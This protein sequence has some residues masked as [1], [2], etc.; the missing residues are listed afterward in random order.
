MKLE[1]NT[2]AIFT[3]YFVAL[4]KKILLFYLMD[5]KRKHKKHR[6]KK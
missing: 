2:K 4:T 1:L 3:E 5:F 6:L